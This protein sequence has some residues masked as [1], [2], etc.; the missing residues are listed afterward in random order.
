MCS[1][2]KHT[3]Y[4]IVPIIAWQLLNAQIYQLQKQKTYSIFGKTWKG[5]WIEIQEAIDY[6]DLNV[7][8]T[9]LEKVL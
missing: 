3:A 6:D 4:R 7:M 2:Q 5:S 9:H 8:K 1:I